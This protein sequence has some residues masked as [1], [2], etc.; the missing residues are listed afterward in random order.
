[1]EA[2]AHTLA[3]DATIMGDSLAPTEVV[4][5]VTAPTLVLYGSD[6]GDWAANSAEALVAALPNP[7]QLALEGQNHAVAWDVLASPLREFLHA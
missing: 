5:T 4:S 3:Y 7:S 6:T 1:M 2:I